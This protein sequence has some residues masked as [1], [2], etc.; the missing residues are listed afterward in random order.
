LNT[1]SFTLNREP[2]IHPKPFNLNSK[3][4]TLYYKHINI[5]L[6]PTPYTLNPE[7]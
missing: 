5:Y 1:E 2:S 6:S 4:R 7:L 3:P